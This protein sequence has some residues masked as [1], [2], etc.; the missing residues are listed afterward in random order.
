MLYL[1]PDEVWKFEYVMFSSKAWRTART[2]LSSNQMSSGH[3]HI[4]QVATNP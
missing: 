4:Y 3:D 1:L 2:A